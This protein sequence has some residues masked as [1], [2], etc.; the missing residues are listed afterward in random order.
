MSR[1]AAPSR[2]PLTA[3]SGLTGDDAA[4]RGPVVGGRTLTVA[5]LNL[6]HGVGSAGEA[7][8]GAC[9]ARALAGL[10]PDLLALQEVD[11]RQP[12]SGGVD[13]TVVAAEST[14][15]RWYRFAAALEGDV[16]GPR[17]RARMTDRTGPAVRDAPGFGVALL[18]RYPVLAWFVHPLPGRPRRPWRGE[19]SGD[20]ARV[21][22]AAVVRTPVGLVCAATTHLSRRPETASR[23]LDVVRRRLTALAVRVSEPGHPPAPTVLLGDLNLLPARVGGRALATALTHPSRAPTRQI[24]HILTLG[25]LVPDGEARAR[26]LDVSDHR[27]LAVA[28]TPFPTPGPL[29]P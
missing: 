26:R 1:P 15:L 17:I 8:N 19:R 27:L 5:T 12:R 28:V 18:S 29:L 9:L 7:P 25:G 10:D 2:G 21:C 20:E 22:L 4:P 16:R 14:G 11:H 23:Q 3:S 6:Q 24:D 13:Q